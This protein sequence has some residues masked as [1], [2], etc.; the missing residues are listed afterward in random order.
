[1]RDIKKIEKQNSKEKLFSSELI[2]FRAEVSLTKLYR[3][4]FASFQVVGSIAWFTK[5]RGRWLN[6]RLGVPIYTVYRFINIRTYIDIHILVRN[7]FQYIHIYK[8]R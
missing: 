8:C 7:I 6:W 2:Q 3:T 5:Y 1:M 4:E